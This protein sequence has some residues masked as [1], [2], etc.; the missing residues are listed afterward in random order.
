VTPEHRLTTIV[1]CHWTEIS[2]YTAEITKRFA[3]TIHAAS[4]VMLEFI[5]TLKTEKID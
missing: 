4:I 1:L 2:V 3:M 5:S